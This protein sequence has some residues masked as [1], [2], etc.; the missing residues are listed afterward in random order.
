MN[1]WTKSNHNPQR[2]MSPPPTTMRTVCNYCEQDHYDQV[3]AAVT[4]QRYTSVTC[5]VDKK[6]KNS[7]ALRLSSS[8][9][10]IAGG[11][12]RSKSADFLTNSGSWDSREAGEVRYPEKCIICRT[13]CSEI[14]ECQQGATAIYDQCA[15]ARVTATKSSASAA[16]ADEA[17]HQPH[18]QQQ[19]P[20]NCVS[21]EE[22]SGTCFGEMSL[23]RARRGCCRDSTSFFFDWGGALRC[24]QVCCCAPAPA[25]EEDQK[26]RRSERG[27][28]GMRFSGSMLLALIIGMFL[29]TTTTIS[30]WNVG[31]LL[32]G[33]GA[34]MVGA[35]EISAGWNLTAAQETGGKFNWGSFRID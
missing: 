19:K 12:K 3:N 17:S 26:C 35:S 27:S 4:G 11:R 28:K 10:L 8:S 33:P 32:M 16:A 5:K 34:V 1:Q 7:G 29:S 15:A 13:N 25:R 31:G 2:I 6:K 14:A 22:A 21:E 18:E 20:V 30:P 9:S 23:N 24:G